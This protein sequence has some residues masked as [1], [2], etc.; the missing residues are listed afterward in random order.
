MGLARYRSSLKEENGS[1][2]GQDRAGPGTALYRER[3][4]ALAANGFP[5]S[6]S[7]LH[8]FPRQE[9]GIVARSAIR[10][11]LETASESS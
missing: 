5:P 6:K 10:V 11:F 9:F 2:G 8:G 7:L 3:G 4:V 1:Q